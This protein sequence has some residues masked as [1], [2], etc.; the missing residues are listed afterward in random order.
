MGIHSG[1]MTGKHIVD[2]RDWPRRDHSHPGL[3]RLDCF[4]DLCDV[5]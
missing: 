1:I 3:L 5:L 4:A 2:I